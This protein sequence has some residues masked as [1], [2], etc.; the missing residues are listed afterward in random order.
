[1]DFKW[2]QALPETLD[3]FVDS[4]WSGELDTRKS[5]SGGAAV[6]DE[7][8][9][10]HWCQS[11][12]SVSLSSGEAEAK[13]CVRGTIEG[14]YIANLLR[15]QGYEFKMILHTDSSAALGHYSRLGPG[16]R[17][18]HLE[19]M[20]LWLQQIIRSGKVSIEWIHGL[21]NPADLYTKY[22][23]RDNIVR[24]M[25]RLGFRMLDVNGDMLYMKDLGKSMPEA[26]SPPD[27]DE[28]EDTL[29][30]LLQ[31]YDT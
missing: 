4:D 21:R 11:Q 19:G 23:S 18:R 28:W 30:G 5:T 6:L 26:Y 10:K 29:Y 8:E 25:T 3:I 9:L 16:K 15:E 27:D 13:S 12:P 20:E 14:L 24:H 2:R 7:N 17:M 22:L 31:K 1:M